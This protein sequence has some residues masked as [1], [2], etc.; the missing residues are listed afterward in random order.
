MT[1]TEQNILDALL[2]LERAIG[3]MPRTTPKPNLLPLFSRLDDLMRALPPTSNPM[4]LH[5]MHKK[6]YQKAR[7][8]LQGRDAENEAGN[9]H[10]HVDNEG[11]K[12]SPGR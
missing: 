5:Y 9:C 4:L 1:Q 11:R 10:G 3:S 8:L 6:S 2:E 7:L 12:W